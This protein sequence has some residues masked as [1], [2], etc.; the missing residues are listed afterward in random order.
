SGGARMQEGILALMQMAKTGQALARLDEAGVLT[1]SV[2]TDPTYGGVAA[3]V[4]A[5]TRLLRA[6][7]R[8][9]LRVAAPPPISPDRRRTPTHRRSTAGGFPD[10]RIPAR[11]R[12]LR[13]HLPPQHPA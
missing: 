12:L 10:R 4:A 6:Q 2:V 9:G 7:P 13:P 8:A 3:P 11:T 5:P 1:V